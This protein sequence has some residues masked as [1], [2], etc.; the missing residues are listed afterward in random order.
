MIKKEDL[1]R[2]LDD[3][4]RCAGVGEEGEWRE[5]CENCARRLAPVSGNYSV[6]MTPPQIIVFECEFLIESPSVGFKYV[7][8]WQKK[9]RSNSGLYRPTP[10]TQPRDN[11]FR[12]C[13][14]QENCGG[15]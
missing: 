5:G 9:K 6:N 11:L 10:T 12:S 8:D 2:L 1:P 7:P 15:G 13:Y 3:V 14:N 4:A